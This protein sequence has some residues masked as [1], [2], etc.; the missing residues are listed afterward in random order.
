MAAVLSMIRLVL[1]L[2]MLSVMRNAA[3]LGFVASDDNDA[4]A[5]WAEVGSESGS[6]GLDGLVHMGSD[7]TLISVKSRKLMLET[8]RKVGS[9][10]AD[11]G[12]GDDLRGVPSGPNP[13]HHNGSPPFHHNWT[14]AK[15][16]IP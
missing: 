4:T 12:Y 11:G 3:G 15:P 14:P 1:L 8:S 10:G 16:Q 7:R 2:A 5:F 9:S 13:L 6:T